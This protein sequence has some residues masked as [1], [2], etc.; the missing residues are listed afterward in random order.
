MT[1]RIHR[2]F[3]GVGANRISDKVLEKMLNLDYLLLLFFLFEA[4]LQDRSPSNKKSSIDPTFHRSG[5]PRQ[6]RINPQ[7]VSPTR[8]E[9]KLNLAC[10]CW[11]RLWWCYTGKHKEKKKKQVLPVL[12]LCTLEQFAPFQRRSTAGGAGRR[13]QRQNSNIF[14]L[15]S[16]WIRLLFYASWDDTW[17]ARC[18]F[19]SRRRSLPLFFCL[20]SPLSRVDGLIIAIAPI[21]GILGT[22]RVLFYCSTS[23]YSV[24]D[25]HW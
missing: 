2:K 8:R 5:Q 21:M 10:R 4:F 18:W 22:N 23:S 6:R 19:G 3:L 13:T 11:W 12:F 7:K 14:C 25:Q 9:R 1:G 15:I 24:I 17:C 20:L 16:K